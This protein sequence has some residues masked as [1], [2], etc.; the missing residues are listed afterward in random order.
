M[1]NSQSQKNQEN[2]RHSMSEKERQEPQIEFNLSKNFNKVDYF[3]LAKKLKEKQTDIKNAEE[4]NFSPEY[5]TN[6][7]EEAETL[8]SEL[9]KIK[10]NN[11]EKELINNNIELMHDLESRITKDGFN[12][13][14]SSEQ[15]SYKKAFSESKELDDQIDSKYFKELLKDLLKSI[16][17]EEIKKFITKHCEILIDNNSEKLTLETIGDTL[18][19]T[20]GGKSIYEKSQSFKNS[21]GIE[22]HIVYFRPEKASFQ[23]GQTIG[24]ILKEPEDWKES[25]PKETFTQGGEKGSWVDFCGLCLTDANLASNTFKKAY[26]LFYKKIQGFSSN[27]IN[28]EN[29]N[30]NL[31]TNFTSINPKIVEEISD[32]SEK[33]DLEKD[34]QSKDFQET[35][36]KWEEAENFWQKA[37]EGNSLNFLLNFIRGMSDRTKRDY[38]WANQTIF[39]QQSEGYQNLAQFEK[40]QVS[41]L[42]DRNDFVT[43]RDKALACLVGNG[44]ESISPRNEFYLRALV[45]ADCMTSDYQSWRIE[46]VLQATD[47]LYQKTNG[48]E[49]TEQ[50][51]DFISRAHRISCG[52]P[53]RM[54]SKTPEY[55]KINPGQKYDQFNEKTKLIEEKF[56]TTTKYVRLSRK[57]WVEACLEDFADENIRGLSKLSKEC[58]D[59]IKDR[60]GNYFRI[61]D[62]YGTELGKKSDGENS[63]DDDIYSDDDNIYTG[64]MRKFL[65]TPFLK[66]LLGSKCLRNNIK[67]DGAYKMDVDAVA[68]LAMIIAAEIINDYDAVKD[69]KDSG[70]KQK[71]LLKK[72]GIAPSNRRA[73]VGEHARSFMRDAYLH[74]REEFINDDA[75]REFVDFF[76]KPRGLQIK[77][78]DG[79]YYEGEL[80]EFEECEQSDSKIKN[81]FNIPFNEDNENEEY[82]DENN[83]LKATKMDENLSDTINIEKPNNSQEIN[84]TLDEEFYLNQ[85]TQKAT[86]KLKIIDSAINHFEKIIKKRISE[87]NLNDQAKQSLLKLTFL[88]T[89]STDD[90]K[91]T[92]NVKGITQIILDKL[93]LESADTEQI[94]NQINEIDKI[95][96][97]RIKLIELK[98]D[99]GGYNYEE[100]L[101]A[102]K[103]HE[104]YKK[105]FEN[106]L[107]EYLQKNPEE[108]QDKAFSNIFSEE[109]SKKLKVF[110]ESLNN[111]NPK[112][113]IDDLKNLRV[114]VDKLSEID[115][116]RKDKFQ[117]IP[118]CEFDFLEKLVEWKI[119][120]KELK[121]HI[122]IIINKTFA[123][124]EKENK[125]DL[126]DTNN[127]EFQ[128]EFFS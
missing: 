109:I 116:Q 43:D 56:A 63:D 17:S 52:K 101:N 85:E 61:N 122:Q 41:I 51:Y 79:G 128:K 66:K 4:Y 21:L 70:F 10:I 23:I 39:S 73:I 111:E 31:E 118:Q 55:K 30:I 58:F 98:T 14:N 6:L 15:E 103:N 81:D 32:K 20:L 117:V 57:N 65:P 77:K 112:K 94:K 29:K 76:L 45:T 123:N 40:K 69:K 11:N 121:K 33:I 89:D 2:Q 72:H 91:N 46:A 3:K 49:I 12:S 102:C 127:P 114:P 36:R 25:A 97:K 35:K 124:L 5:I 34:N 44:N 54:G 106:S 78:K 108:N 48:E 1:D 90:E 38:W 47:A 84:K 83:A 24:Y 99:L 68:A 27:K 64:H 104:Y 18:S 71:E 125:F 9:G 105:E 115:K 126:N 19:I 67:D 93:N 28:V 113:I 62:K 13:L 26:E 60:K 80:I 74:Y 50:S 16:K 87:S 95:R 82:N 120:D 7:K 92:I 22:T 42:I 86:D 8:A 59:Q 53:K 107:T 96:T 88:E 75:H 110:E 100:N 119:S 37:N